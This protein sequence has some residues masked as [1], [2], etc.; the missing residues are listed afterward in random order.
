MQRMP[1]APL[2][3]S[4]LLLSG[5]FT[6]CAG[7][8]TSGSTDLAVTPDP[9]DVATCRTRTFTAA[10]ADGVTWSLDGAGQLK[11]GLYTAPLS[12][13][14]PASAMV[15]ATSGDATATAKITL[16]SAFPGAAV[17]TG[18]AVSSAAAEVVHGVTARGARAYALLEGHKDM[19]HTLAVV[20]S[21]DGGLTWKAPVTLPSGERLA[22]IAID[23][24]DDDTV[25]VTVHSLDSGAASA[26]D[27][28][29]SKDGG[30]TFSLHRL[31]E[32]GNGEAQEADVASP[33]GG[34]V[35]VTAPATWQDGNGAQGATLLVWRDTT[36]GDGLAPIV[37]LDNGYGAMWSPGVERRLADG[38]VIETNSGRRGPQLATNRKGKV[39]LLTTDYDVNGVDEH[40]DLLCSTDGGATW[41]DPVQAVKGKPGDMER[42]RVAVGP[43]GS[44]VVVAWNAYNDASLDTIGHTK[45]SVSV[46]GGKTFGAAHDHPAVKDAGGGDQSV[47]AAE[48]AID[49]A[50][51]IWFARDVGEASLLLDKSCDQGETL[52]GAFAIP[53]AGSHVNAVFFESSAGLFAG[54]SRLGDTDTGVTVVRLQEP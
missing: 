41:G 48:V 54:A 6:G 45:Y 27:L 38:R 17:D 40:D 1:F 14:S 52:S 2:S 21:D 30:K 25:Y 51:V 13:P 33:A 32:G 11:D 47:S 22:S 50:G 7:N 26:L 15:T 24:E 39:C 4:L 36:K 53:I 46:D 10:P 20:R 5:A 12:V 28:A 34:T 35:V 49:S 19:T 18:R 43:D 23:A 3:I 31:F 29:V 44:L 9:A 8:D 42:A 37:A 16:A